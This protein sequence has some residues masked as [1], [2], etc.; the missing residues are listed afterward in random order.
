[1]GQGQAG[2]QP[3]DPG[4]AHLSPAPQG[5][6]V[7]EKEEHFL[8]KEEKV[9]YRDQNGRLLDDEEVKALQG[10]VE[11]KTRYETRTRVIDE[12][13]NEIRN[14][15]IG[16]R[17]DE[18]VAPQRPDTEGSNPETKQWALKEGAAPQEP[19]KPTIGEGSEESKARPASDPNAATNI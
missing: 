8:S 4:K 3:E 16:V 11:F 5:T 1:M 12:N 2:V 9:E 17:E 6:P 18:G 15:L 19:E 10:K 7:A 13:G 14:E